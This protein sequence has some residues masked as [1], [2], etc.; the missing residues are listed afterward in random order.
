MQKSIK[1]VTGDCDKQHLLPQKMPVVVVL[2]RLRS[3]FNTGNIF[4]LS[5][6]TSVEKIYTCGYT[7]TP[8]HAKLE[9][10]ARGCDQ[11]VPFEHAETSLEAV[12]KLKQQGFRIYA[13]ETVENAIPYWDCDIQ[14]PAAFVFGNEALG[15]AQETLE[16]CDTFIQLPCYG[17]KNSINVGNCAG[18]ILFDSLRQWAQKFSLPQD[19]FKGHTDSE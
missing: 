18:I 6:A 19:A 14:F 2:D 5:E 16:L 8:P 10:T 15:V 9:K 13:V 17:E 4:R 12:Q 11:R 1:V 3:A 7:P